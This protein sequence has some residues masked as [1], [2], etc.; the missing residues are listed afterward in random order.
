MIRLIKK[1]LKGYGRAA[2]AAPLL[3]FVEAVLELMM[4]LVVSHIRW[5]RSSGRASCWWR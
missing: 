3:K 1:Y 4:P 5:E 2:V